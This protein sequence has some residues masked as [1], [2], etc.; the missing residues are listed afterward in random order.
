MGNIIDLKNLTVEYKSTN[1]NKIDIV[2][3]VDNV[4]LSIKKGEIYA[5]AGES[6][7]GKSTLSK[8]IT[9]LVPVKSGDIFYNGKSILN[10]TKEER[11]E[12]PKQVQMVFQNP[13][14]SLNPKM[15][16]GDILKEPLDINTSFSEKAKK[17][18]IN[19]VLKDVGLNE[20]VVNLY[21]HEFSGGQRQ[22]IAIARALILNPEF[23]IADLT[24]S[25]ASFTAVSGKPTIDI[26]GK[27]LITSVSTQT[28]YALIPIT[29]PVFTLFTIYKL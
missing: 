11:K 22:R 28:S 19:E 6:G 15:K 5:L 29:V 8:A 4:S 1:N 24:L 17:A 26:E 9:K 10:Q 2:R 18:L 23:L 3:A 27:E 14:S 12:Y 7:C 25:R 21:P 20:N 13:Y 16:I